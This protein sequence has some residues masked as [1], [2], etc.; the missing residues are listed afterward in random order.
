MTT[1]INKISAIAFTIFSLS[2]AGQFS[3]QT[4][5]EQE[6]GSKIVQDSTIVNI[7]LPVAQDSIS[8]V[9][10]EKKDFQISTTNTSVSLHTGN[11]NRVERT[12]MAGAVNISED[13]LRGVQMAAF[14][15]VAE[16]N[17]IGTQLA[18]AFNI[19]NGKVEGVQ[20]AGIANVVAD[21]V[22]GSQIAGISNVVPYAEGFQGA[23]VINIS[24]DVQGVQLAG[25]VNIAENEVDGV[26]LSGYFNYAKKLKGVQIAYI[27]IADTVESGVPLGF[28]SYVKKGFHQVELSY[29]DPMMGNVAFKT[30]THKFYNIFIAGY[31]HDDNRPMWSYG[32]GLGTQLNHGKRFYSNIELSAQHF[33]EFDFWV[34]DIN[35]L[36]TLNVNLGFNISPRVS[37]NA[38][39]SL[40]VL[41]TDTHNNN[42][43]G[44]ED[45]GSNNMIYQ[46][47]VDYTD[48]Q[49]WVGYKA[50]IRF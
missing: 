19:N 3:A 41:I 38:G 17:V 46:E 45:F 42:L 43:G 18:G 36:S 12:V 33:Q 11:E 22:Q 1:R 34:E 39:P 28:F 7:S 9:V 24:R 44:F 26:Q 10:D 35:L 5:P 37:I 16:G 40:N 20:L 47:T 2:F 48:I 4:Q 29:S 21:S 50:A 6:E 49:I 32:Y 8:S 27:N 25:C 15:N 23:G 31:K 14:G 30:G 13:T